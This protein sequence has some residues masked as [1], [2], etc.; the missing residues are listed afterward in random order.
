[1]Q[2]N[3]SRF[4]GFEEE[5]N[6]YRPKP[7]SALREILL[8]LALVGRP[9]LV[10]DL[11]SGTGLSTRY[12]ADLA[13]LVVGVEPNDDMRMKAIS[14]TKEANVI[15]RKGLSSQTGIADESVDIVTCSQSL[16]WMEPKS[17]FKEVARILRP[18]GI[19][20]AYDCDW[21]PTTGIWQVDQE[22]E[23]CTQRLSSM[24]LNHS[25]QNQVQKWAKHE[26]LS[27]M[28]ESGCFRY[29]KEIVVHHTEDGTSDRLV[30][31]L[32]SQGGIQSLL[33]AGR[34][35]EELGINAIRVKFR[36]LLGSSD[37]RWYW[38]YRVRIGV[39]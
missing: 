22:Y 27:R 23:A 38:S 4:S 13:E 14:A 5:Y 29:L 32:L 8:Q 36:E 19:F 20:A 26:H 25:E 28:R 17:T 15:Y 18:N 10:V 21:P 37:R 12:W 31:L 1:M 16:H 6:E 7:P 24:E 11:G 34:S 39:K 30:G 3:L 33:K 9:T 35:E 2:G